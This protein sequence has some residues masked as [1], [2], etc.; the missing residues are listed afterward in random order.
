M[1][2][3]FMADLKHLVAITERLGSHDRG[4]SRKDGGHS[5]SNASHSK[6]TEDNREK[7]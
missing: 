1:W 5:R 4:H 2:Q 7:I 6:K 3:I